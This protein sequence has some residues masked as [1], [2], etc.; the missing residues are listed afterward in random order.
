MYLALF[1]LELEKFDVLI[2][3]F[4]LIFTPETVRFWGVVVVAIDFFIFLVLL[5][6]LFY[7]LLS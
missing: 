1:V 2:F 3:S 7:F 5:F 6:Y 4:S